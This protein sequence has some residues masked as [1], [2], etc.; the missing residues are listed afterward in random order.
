MTIT[1]KIRPQVRLTGGDGNA[2][3]VMGDARK[4]ARKA[5]WTRAE[6]EEYLKEAMG[7]DYN[8]LLAVTMK[9]FDVS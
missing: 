7:G 4:A 5:G 3:A 8:H 6:V 2:F 1:T 9:Y